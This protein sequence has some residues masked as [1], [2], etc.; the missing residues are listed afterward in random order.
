[1]EE[2]ILFWKIVFIWSLSAITS[3]KLTT[4]AQE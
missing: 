1:M 2:K 4:E 3:L